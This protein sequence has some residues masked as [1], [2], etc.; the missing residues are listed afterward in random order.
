[1]HTIPNYIAGSYSTEGSAKTLMD[2]NGS[3]VAEIFSATPSVLRQVKRAIMR[4]GAALQAIPVEVIFEILE[5]L[6]KEY[7]DS[8]LVAQ[9][10]VSITGTSRSSHRISLEARRKWTSQIRGVYA[11][12]ARSVRSGNEVSV[13]EPS[14][15]IVAVLPQNSGEE[16]F[17]VLAHALIARCPILIRT[18]SEGESSLSAIEFIR[19][20]EKVLE[21][22]PTEISAAIR[23]SIAVVNVFGLSSKEDLLEA[24]HMTD[25]NYLIFGSEE[26][27]RLAKEFCA[28]RG[29]RKIITMGTGLA[30]AFV[31]GDADVDSAAREIIE[32]ATLNNGN[33]CVCTKVVYA[34]ES[35]ADAL[36]A[37]LAA[38]AAPL[39]GGS[40]TNDSAVLGLLRPSHLQARRDFVR[41]LGRSLLES[42]EL[43]DVLVEETPLT[44]RIA[45][46]P[47]PFVIV[48]RVPSIQV[49]VETFRND[50]RRE[51]V[52]R[53]I[54]TAVFTSTQSRFLE[55]AR[56]IPSY[57]VRHNLGTHRVNPLQDI[58]GISLFEEFLTPKL[59]DLR[60][61]QAEGFEASN[62]Y[63]S[64]AVC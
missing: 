45:E 22:R 18:S 47:G 31:C 2:L 37:R 43:F 30:S 61:L 60:P 7:F 48:K 53:A 4:G 36:R 29:V 51:G 49:G 21:R 63:P 9:Q 44:E 64:E 46:V 14:G 23:S 16:S 5:E 10:V 19:S 62:V 26:T 52:S 3:P 25:A 42:K 41:G 34:E 15:P 8:A 59:L 13:L 35:I 12:R 39:R 50:L 20:L 11:E 6:S 28:K 54:C 32:A 27:M 55:I 38:I 56:M 1:M 33:E 17:Y 58:H 57:C 24:L 40:L